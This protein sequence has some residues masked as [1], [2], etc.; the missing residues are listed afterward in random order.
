MKPMMHV[1]VLAGLFALQSEGHASSPPADSVHFC[2][3]VD[4]E[5][6][7]RDEPRPAG[8]WAAD[9][10]AGVP[11]D[12]R[13]FY[14]LP[15]D[16]PYRTEVVDSM[17]AGILDLQTFFG[18]QMEAHGRGNTTFGIE[19]DDQGNPVVH[20]VD[21]DY[22]DSHYSSRG[23]TEGEI[24][25]AYDN[26]ANII[27]VIMDVSARTA[28]GRGTGS[29]GSGWAMVYGEWDWFAAAHELGHAFGLNHDF[30]DDK[31]VMSY[32]RADRSSAELSACAA[33]FLSAHP[34]FNAN[35]PLENE[36]P[37]TVELVSS[38]Y[39]F[40]SVSTPV[41]LRVRD[42][43]GIHQVIL[44][45]RPKNPFL[46]GTPDVKSCRGLSGE[47]DTVVE[48]SF[49]G[50]LPSDNVG[51]EAEAHTTLANTV[52]HPI[53]V[54][55][56]DTDGN[57]TSTVSPI[58]FTLEAGH[59]PQHIATF[60]R[61][62]YYHV[63]GMAVSLDG[64][65]LA[66]GASARVAL[67]NVANRET[68][69]TF[70]HSAYT[71]PAVTFSPDGTLVA[72][73]SREGAVKVW[74]V[75][76]KAEVATLEGHAG[77]VASLDFSPDGSMLAS[78][79][80][81]S[82]VKTWNVA[83][84]AAIATLEGHNERIN[85]V[86]FV[87]GGKLASVSFSGAVRLWDVST[88]SRISTIETDAKGV[89]AFSPDGA[90]LASPSSW[91]I[92]LWDLASGTQTGA[93]NDSRDYNRAYPVFSPDGAVLAVAASGLI[94]IW[95]VA[96]RELMASIS[97]GPGGVRRLLFSPD[98]RM[99]IGNDATSNSTTIKF[100]DVSE[101]APSITPVSQRTSQVR[102]AILGVARRDDPNVSSFAE[103]TQTHLDGITAL[104]LNGNGITSLKPGDFDGLTSLEELRLYGNQLTSLP[105]GI[106]SGLSSLRTLRFGLNQLT[107]LP[108][109]LLEGLT[110]LTDLRM[111]GNRLTTLPD[112]IF[113]GLT[114]LTTL[115]LDGN[116]ADP[117]PIAVSLE[118]VGDGQFK[119]VAPTGAP[120][121]IVLP[122]RV[123]NGDISGGATAIT[124]P[125]GSVDSGT[126]TV[127]RTVGTTA[128]VT[129]DVGPLPGLPNGH[130]G[131]AL[132]KSSDLPLEIFSSAETGTTT[133][134]T[135]FNGDGRTDFADFFLFA[136][137]Y[138]GTDSRF[139]LD[140][141]GT[142][143]FAD[144]FKFIDAFGA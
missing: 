106:F 133:A 107:S 25:R 130:S 117:L 74:S 56:V 40:G 3:P 113:V 28:H 61:P 87:T 93:V 19:T 49:D 84:W 129:V 98:G 21:G 16:R 116:A 128:A 64:A 36:S 43:D 42:D 105:E 80:L 44:L 6:L 1:A 14:F 135:D 59:S 90:L 66:I 33:E 138:G 4:P 29:K 140:G 18:E 99:L 65:L 142:V 34:Y 46:G 94:E 121:E 26:S 139:D 51:T 20:R 45:V 86:A 123:R 38:E 75:T 69:A 79:S 141:S 122:I 68:V 100:W 82:T 118:K 13:L 89:V 15:N 73:G 37:P 143:D 55:V 101:W 47:T 8:K 88:K 125:R 76:R 35:V 144:F 112:S 103:V 62:D 32:G 11:R 54:V 5:L 102:D 136:D 134:A 109:G 108:L 63:E 81:D 78:G 22:G 24:A 39:P 31:Y 83:T 41:Q 120:F 7:Q 2:L 10:D 132:V 131:Y 48:F 111:I 57:R 53:H 95:D 85:K 91:A 96:K 23:Y 71:I 119:A 110:A 27:L 52:Q 115:A 72:A 114:G 97:G 124:I 50:R 9:L 17:K 137:A 70:R 60:D 126:L 58:R 30:R 92:K 77:R 67:L 104:Y 12:V 127:I